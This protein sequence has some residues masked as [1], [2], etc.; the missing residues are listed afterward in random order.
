MKS[1]YLF[2]SVLLMLPA[3]AVAQQKNS[4]CPSLPI[5]AGLQWEERANTGFLA[6]KARNED[7]SKSINLL[8][9]SRDPELR[10]SRS[11]RAEPGVFS[12]AS[13]HW[14]TPELAGRDEAYVASRRITVVELGKDQYAQIWIDA[15][16][17]QALGE[18]LTLAGQLDVSA[19]TAY[20]VSGN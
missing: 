9:T 14:Y 17:P 15:P 2:L 19:G 4:R 13:F 3:V 18:L 11:R 5:S 12:G 10:L 16:S 20:L 7:G 8:L 1:V 6:C